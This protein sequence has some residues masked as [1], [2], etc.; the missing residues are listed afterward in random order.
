[1]SGVPA[2]DSQ[3]V[4]AE[5]GLTVRLGGFAR[6]AIEQEC[7]RLGVPVDELVAFAAMYYLADVDSGR[8]ARRISGDR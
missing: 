1:M 4:Q 2:G 5:P 7:A 6:D 3:A 8:I